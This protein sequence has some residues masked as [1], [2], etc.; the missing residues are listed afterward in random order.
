M[1]WSSNP[2]RERNFFLHTGTGHHSLGVVDS[3]DFFTWYE[4]ARTWSWSR[5][6]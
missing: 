1:S 4:S 2:G 5:P 3:M 6:K